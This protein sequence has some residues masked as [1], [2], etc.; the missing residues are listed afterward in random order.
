MCVTFTNKEG[1]S[2]RRRYYY[3]RCTKVNNEGGELARLARSAPSGCTSRFITISSAFL[4]T[5]TI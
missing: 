1:K 4:W 2:G 3:Y 5:P